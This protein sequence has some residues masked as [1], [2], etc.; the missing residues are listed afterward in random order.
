MQTSGLHNLAENA[1]ALA[2]ITAGQIRA[3]RALIGWITNRPGKGLR[4]LG[5]LHQEHRERRDRSAF[6]YAR[7]ASTGV[8]EGGDHISRAGRYPR[9]RSGREIEKGAAWLAQTDR[10]SCRTFRSVAT[11]IATIRQTRAGLRLPLPTSPV[12]GGL[13]RATSRISGR[14]HRIIWRHQADDE[15]KFFDG[16][17]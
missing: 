5:N 6:K 14:Q 10:A 13:R 12:T 16:R 1:Y 17:A 11:Q 9:R 2:M 15:M 3:A 4:C 7:R 8:R